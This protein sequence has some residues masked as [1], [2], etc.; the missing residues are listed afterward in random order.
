VSLSEIEVRR[1][2]DQTIREVIGKLTANAR[3]PERIGRRVLAWEFKLRQAESGER[4]LQLAKRLGI[5]VSGASQAVADAE[6][7]LIEIKHFTPMSSHPD[8]P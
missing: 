3:D 6:G 7:A 2:K 4:L 1:I 8:A 5:S